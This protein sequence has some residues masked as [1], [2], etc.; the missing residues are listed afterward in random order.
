M[1]YVVRDHV[2]CGKTEDAAAGS[3]GSAADC[4]VASYYETGTA[5]LTSAGSS[6]LIKRLSARLCVQ[7]EVL[8][9]LQSEVEE[10]AE[11]RAAKAA[12]S[13]TARRQSVSGGGAPPAA[14]GLLSPA[15]GAAPH[16]A[17]AGGAALPPRPGSACGNVGSPGA[18]RA[19]GPSTPM[20]L[21]G[22]SSRTLSERHS[23]CVVR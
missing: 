2:G 23:I 9:V 3:L 22:V 17:S 8:D 5:E 1:L 4:K 20:P 7:F 12:R 18:R 14:A 21:R 10:A 16:R 11:A 6:L 15:K 19:D 13:A